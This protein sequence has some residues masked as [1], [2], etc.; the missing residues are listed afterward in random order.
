MIINSPNDEEVSYSSD[1]ITKETILIQ[2][3]PLI[4]RDFPVLTQQ[5]LKESAKNVLNQQINV[6]DKAYQ[7]KYPGSSVYNHIV[8]SVVQA[9]IENK[10]TDQTYSK[11]QT[12][13]GDG[14]SLVVNNLNG[15]A[16]GQQ[17]ND[18]SIY[19]NGSVEV[20]EKES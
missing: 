1:R 7:V 13:K 16:I 2:E 10:S 3:R 20:S 5:R 12:E 11:L 9:S 18:L 4:Q 14:N 19:A 17:M 15:V 6:K 8:A